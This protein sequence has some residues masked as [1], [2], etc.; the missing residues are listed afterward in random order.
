VL[1]VITEGTR[2]VWARL[3]SETAEEMWT[4][5]RGE[6]TIPTLRAL[7]DQ[8]GYRVGTTERRVTRLRHP[9]WSSR[10]ATRAIS[11]NA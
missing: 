4:S 8:L 9:G 11:T 10:S 5:E 6:D 3:E 1:L 2:A 7:A